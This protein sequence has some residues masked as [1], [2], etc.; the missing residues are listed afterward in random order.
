MKYILALSILLSSNCF[1][2]IYAETGDHDMDE[3]SHRMQQ[4]DTEDRLQAIESQQQEAENQRWQKDL[5][6][7]VNP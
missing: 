6:D 3:L 2:Y 4:Q 7:S 1:A 5:F